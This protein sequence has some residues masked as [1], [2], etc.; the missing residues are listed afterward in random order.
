[1]QRIKTF[2]LTLILFSG[3]LSFAVGQTLNDKLTA[4]KETHGF[5]F[6]KLESNS[7]FSEKYEIYFEQPLDHNNPES[8]FFTQRILI[9]HV[10]FNNPVVFVTEGYAAH[11]AA[12]SKYIN[13]LSTLLNA[14]QVVAEHRFYG[15]S[16]PSNPDWQYLNTFQAASDH[17]RIIE[18]IRDIYSGPIMNTGISK[19][20]QTAMYH[21]FYFPDDVDVT[22]GYVCPLNF[23]IEDKRVYQFLDQVGDSSSRSK[24]LNYQTEMLKNKDN[25]LPAFQKLANK[26]NLTYQMGLLE[27]YELTVLEYSFAFWQW[28]AIDPDSIPMF[29]ENPELMV[30]HLNKIAGI[31]WVSNEG[32]ARIFPFFYQAMT[33]IGFYGYDIAP[34]KEYISFTENPTFTFTIP[35][36][37]KY[38]FNPEIM[39]QVDC[40]IR[41]EAEHMIFI[42]GETDPWSSTAVDITHEK[43]VLKIVKPGGNHLTR[44]SNLPAEYQA[45][46][47]ETLK[48]WLNLN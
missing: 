8:E 6:K 18:L 34:F 25:Y 35:E 9:S 21:R 40:F 38:S 33:E 31:D 3:L 17:H 22:V 26:K 13:E 42:Y 37:I 19:G 41:H 44:I 30:N 20:G 46:V 47:L 48:G 4:L 5:T 7:F 10:D 1:M 12:N 43:D 45:Q 14:N 27:G 28:G 11:Y 39:H 24:I 23:S 2:T 16:L 32:I 36:N 29:P 15:E